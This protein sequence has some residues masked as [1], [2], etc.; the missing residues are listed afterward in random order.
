[1]KVE[2]LQYTKNADELCGVAAATCY[3]SSSWKKAL[4]HSA[5]SGHES[6][7]E[8]TIYTFRVSNVSRVLLAQLTRHRLCSF[9]VES[10]R[11]VKLDGTHPIVCPKSIENFDLQEKFAQ[12]CQRL[13]DFYCELLNVGVPAEDARYILPQG[14]ATT[15]IISCNARELKHI[16]ELRCC[17]RAQWEIRKMADLMYKLVYPTAP[18]IFGKAGPGCVNGKGCHEARPCGECRHLEE[19]QGEAVQDGGAE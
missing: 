15:I 8:H 14:V 18:I 6:V 4:Q 19:W 12:V 5:G 7:I 11:Y 2:L 13:M 1:M 16:L 17:H 9:S 10:Q 3:H